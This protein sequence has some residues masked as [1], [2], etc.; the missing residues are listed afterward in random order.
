MTEREGWAG[1]L[2]GTT[3]LMSLILPGAP[4]L[5]RGRAAV[6][7]AALLLWAFLVW[8][9]VARWDRVRAA[10]GAGWD[11][12]LAL[13]TLVVL[14]V[15]V[16]S[17]SLR[18][19]RKH[20]LGATRRPAT[21]WSLASRS[22]ARNRVAVAG[23]LAVGALYL[24]ALLTPFLAPHDPTFQGDLLAARFLPPSS[25]H[26]LG[27]DHFARDVLSRMLY[28]ARVSLSIGFVAVGI[29]ITIGTLVGAISGFVGGRVDALIMR[30]VDM[31]IA[32]PRLVL[33][34]T[35][36]ALFEPSIFLIVAVLGL[37]QWPQTTRIVR[38]EVL[39]LRE[40]E[41]IQA[42]EA[43]GFSRS[44]LILRHVIP[45]VLA[46]VI[47]AATL[48]IG[49]TIVL[50]AG[51]SFLGLGVQPP[52]PSWGTMVADGRNNLL[53]AW[54]ITTFPGLAIVLAVLSFNLAGDGLRDALDP[55]LRR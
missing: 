28:G 24:V 40:R 47:V 36:I 15:G 51:L 5:L 44:R 45:N 49:D 22:F 16:W 26:P 38:G 29:S 41:F 54:W 37:T 55:R 4:Q 31:V 30:F 11:H 21:Q 9:A 12:G 1:R 19:V 35:I 23:G 50:E 18:D 2:G 48:G 25:G 53:G 32:F 17:W 27:T 6:G 52:T 33:L 42:G 13:V 8:V 7:V 34:I 20:A 46:P 3:F 43:L 39:S 10:V 14:T